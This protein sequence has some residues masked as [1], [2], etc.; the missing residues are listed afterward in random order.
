MNIS[1]DMQLYNKWMTNEHRN[2]I[3]AMIFNSDKKIFVAKRV[4]LLSG[5]QMPQGGIDSG[6]SLE[7]ALY[8]E[9]EEEIGT[10]KFVISH[11]LPF[12]VSYDFPYDLGMKIY[13]GE[14]VGQKL[15]WFLLRFDGQDSDIVIQTTHPEFAEWQW[16][17]ID[18]IVDNTVFFKKTMYKIVID[19]FMPIL[20]SL[21]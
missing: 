11:V 18:E 12:T 14:Y 16:I 15:K 5:L 10:T 7:E 17:N 19:Y 13:K 20:H 1:I 9:L 21:E 6:E 2:G 3:G 8:R 4:N